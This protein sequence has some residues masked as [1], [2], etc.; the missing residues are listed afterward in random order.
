MRR[1]LKA[2]LANSLSPER[3]GCWGL[4]TCPLVCLHVHPPP[5]VEPQLS[6]Q[7]WLRTK[8][9]SLNSPSSFQLVPLFQI[10]IRKTIHLLGFSAP[11]IHISSAC[12]LCRPTQAALHKVVAQPFSPKRTQHH[13]HPVCSHHLLL[14]S[15]LC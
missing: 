6:Q 2:Y 5:G 14:R 9:T 10:S 3:S 13:P 11:W 4:C 8:T 7:L 15:Q 1:F 12:L